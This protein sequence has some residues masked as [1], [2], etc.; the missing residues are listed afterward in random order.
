[1]RFYHAGYGLFILIIRKFNIACGSGEGNVFI[2]IG[3]A[4]EIK[5][6]CACGFGGENFEAEDSCSD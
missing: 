3:E 5:L 1:M 6:Q 2:A 4:E